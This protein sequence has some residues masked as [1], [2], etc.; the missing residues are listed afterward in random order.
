MTGIFLIELVED[1]VLLTAIKLL[2][3]AYAFDLIFL[4]LAKLSTASVDS[5]P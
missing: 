5:L 2:L 4:S 1:S 3:L